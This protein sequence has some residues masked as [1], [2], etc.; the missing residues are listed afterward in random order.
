[1]QQKYLVK[2][3]GLGVFL[4]LCIISVFYIKNDINN[5]Y[6]EITNEM[7]KEYPQLSEENE[8]EF[9]KLN[10]VREYT[11]KNSV[12]ANGSDL[13][14][15]VHSKEVASH[16]D[17]TRLI[18]MFELSDNR[19]GGFY[20]DGFSAMLATFYRTMGYQSVALALVIDEVNSHVVTLVK[21]QDKWIVEDATFN[22]T[23]TDKTGTPL[24]IREIIRL[25]KE[26]RG[27]EIVTK[28]GTEKNRYAVSTY[29]SDE[30]GSAYPII[31]VLGD[32]NDIYLYKIDGR[33]IYYTG[34]YEQLYPQFLKDGYP[35]QKEYLYMYPKFCI[36]MG[37]EQ[38]YEKEI[39]QRIIDE[40]NL[41]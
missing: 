17:K 34:M 29:S 39:L 31:E 7:L 35:C 10:L 27:D 36:S 30:W 38:P 2:V 41:Q 11:Y 19:K 13:V 25:L 21:Y 4:A 20:C 18:K 37:E 40:I 5:R 22:H 24:D 15:G 28:R 12:F 16:F 3:G 14:L 33:D 23:Y 6:T 8:N 1:M 26:R 9:E 32:V